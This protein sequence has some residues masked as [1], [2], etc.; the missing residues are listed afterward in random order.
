MNITFGVEKNIND[1]DANPFRYCGEYFDAETGTIYLRARYYDPAIGRFIS[2]DS[3]AGRKSDPLSLNLYTYCQN[4]PIRY[5][6]PSGHL[7]TELILGA[8][9]IGGAIAL[10]SCDNK[11]VGKASVQ[12]STSKPDYR[13]TTSQVATSTNQTS[14]TTRT[15]T[16]TMT[17]T[18]AINKKNSN[19]TVL[20]NTSPVKHFDY[21]NDAVDGKYGAPRDSGIPHGGIDFYPADSYVN[22]GSSGGLYGS[23][24]T[25]KNVYAMANGTVVAYTNDFIGTDAIIVNHGDYFA[26]YGEI[27]TEL[28]VGDNVTQGQLLGPM[29]I[30]IQ[31]TLMLHLEILKGS[32]PE[33]IF[34]GGSD[35]QQYQIDPTYVYDYPDFGE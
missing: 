35:R 2:R 29:K 20:K 18:V 9:V 10:T 30:S 8:I 16:T 24:G 26:L 25:P 14:K 21:R 17:T 15:T 27:S 34:L 12:T 28:R 6:D 4:N 32:Y 19:Q 23:D 22:N 3:Y 11:T 1:S 31:N 7:I 5:V 13:G 33:G